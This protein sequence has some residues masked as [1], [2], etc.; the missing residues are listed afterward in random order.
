VKVE[1]MTVKADAQTMLHMAEAVRA[2]RLAIP[3]GER[4]ALKDASKAHVPAEKGVAGRLLL[5]A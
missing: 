3:L 4:F 5:L 1:Y 2:A